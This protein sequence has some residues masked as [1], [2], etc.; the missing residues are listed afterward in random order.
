MGLIK[1]HV[2]MLMAVVK[3][4][5]CDDYYVFFYMLRAHEQTERDRRNTYSNRRGQ[6][7]VT[8][9]EVKYIH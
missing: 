3:Y 4:F 8:S 9:N 6:F 7:A 2:S 5:S 1:S